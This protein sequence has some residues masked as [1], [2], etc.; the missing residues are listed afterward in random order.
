MI[1]DAKRWSQ[2]DNFL[3]ISLSRSDFV[4][5][6]YKILKD[7]NPSLPILVRECSSIE[8][9]IWARFEFGQETRIDVTNKS[10]GDI[11]KVV[12]ELVPKSN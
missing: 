12:N 6:H 5:L 4:S 7:A 1:E 11:L 2:I 8:P 3:F 10:S 9:R